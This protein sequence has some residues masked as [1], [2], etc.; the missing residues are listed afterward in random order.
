MHL[1]LKFLCRKSLDVAALGSNE[2]DRL[3]SAI[4][5]ARGTCW[6]GAYALASDRTHLIE[7][8]AYGMLA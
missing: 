2:I 1:A 4:Y 8:Y 3:A 7:T 5:R 6:V